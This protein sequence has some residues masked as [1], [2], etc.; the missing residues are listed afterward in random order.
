[1]SGDTG[2]ATEANLEAFVECGARPTFRQTA[3][4]AGVPI[5]GCALQRKPLRQAMVDPICRAGR[6]IRYRLRKQVVEPIFVQIKQARSVP[7]IPAPRSHQ[8]PW[9]MGKG[10]HRR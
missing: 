1:V 7:P 2:F 8:R 5:A 9:R 10:L 6:R 3:S 4:V